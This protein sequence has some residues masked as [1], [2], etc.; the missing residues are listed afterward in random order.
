MKIPESL[1]IH[2]DAL[3]KLSSIPDHS[4][5]LA[6]CD[7][8]YGRTGADV[9]SLNLLNRL[10][11][12]LYELPVFGGFAAVH[13]AVFDGF[14]YQG[15][16]RNITFCQFYNF[17]SFCNSLM[18]LSHVTCFCILSY[19]S[20]KMTSIFPSGSKVMIIVSFYTH[21]AQRI[22]FLSSLQSF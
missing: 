11:Q 21:Y 22:V 7:L 14:R 2:G 12:L 1:L 20:A 13:V 5:D 9:D 16:V 6:L 18:I 17:R 10:L 15:R 19:L 3:E 4:I 8:P